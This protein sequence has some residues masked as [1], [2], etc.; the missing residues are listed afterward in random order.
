MG[1]SQFFKFELNTIMDK[2]LF[3]KVVVLALTPLLF[4]MGCKDDLEIGPTVT[5]IR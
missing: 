1:Y 3:Y 4:L 2:K 5:S